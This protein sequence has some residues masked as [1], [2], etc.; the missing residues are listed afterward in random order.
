VGIPEPIQ[1]SLQGLPSR[2]VKMHSD[3]AQEAEAQPPISGRVGDRT[4]LCEER[5]VVGR[6]RRMAEGRMNVADAN[7]FYLPGAF[8]DWGFPS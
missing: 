7:R 4:S 5:R 2:G 6:A 3:G 8:R 1:P